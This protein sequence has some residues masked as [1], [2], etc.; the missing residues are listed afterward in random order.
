M[1]SKIT[2]APAGPT[3]KPGD[4]HAQIVV[5]TDSG[6]SLKVHVHPEGSGNL[7]FQ[8]TPSGKDISN[9]DPLAHPNMTNAVV[10]AASGKVYVYNENGVQ[11]TI[12]LKDFPKQ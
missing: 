11:A 10:G 5:P 4:D 1:K 3:A 7:Q 8:Q 12:P 9:V 2:N 6:T